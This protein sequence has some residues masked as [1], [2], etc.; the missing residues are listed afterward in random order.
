[1]TMDNADRLMTVTEP[2]QALCVGCRS[3]ADQF[4]SSAAQ[5]FGCRTTRRDHAAPERHDSA[6]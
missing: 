5:D 6:Q 1:M 2:A 3:I 4:R